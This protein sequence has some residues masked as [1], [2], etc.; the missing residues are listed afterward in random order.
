MNSRSN[1]YE[2][3]IHGLFIA[4]VCVMTMVV[5]IPV[6]MTNGYI[7]LGDS[8]ILL[9]AIF[10]GKRYGIIAGGIGSALA[11]ILTGYA[12]WALFTLII[13]ALM[14]YVAAQ[15]SNY[16]Y[17]NSN[18]ISA[19]TLL[20]SIITSLTMIFGYFIGGVILKGTIEASLASVPAN[21]T[22]AFLGMALF[23]AIGKAF[24]KLHIT[25]YI[26]KYQN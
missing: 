13:K 12:H 26:K 9:I 14:G 21:M 6:P 4:I 17:S 10:F 24:D 7:H 15:I 23:F 8:C 22:Q 19:N 5:Q 20:A 16:R 25:N 1:I 18:F 3:V 2:L 11:D